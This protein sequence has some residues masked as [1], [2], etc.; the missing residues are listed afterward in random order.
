MHSLFADI[1]S[2]IAEKRGYPCVIQKVNTIGGGCINQCYR[3]FT[4]VGSFFLKINRLPFSGDMF[5]KERVGLLTLAESGVVR[6]PEVIAIGHSEG[7][8]YLLLE[9]IE[10]GAPTPRHWQLAG[11]CLA[12]MHYI[13]SSGF[14]WEYDNYI[15]SLPQSNRKHSCFSDFFI[16][17]RLEPQLKRAL[18]KQL[19]DNKIAACFEKL[20]V[21]LP[22]LLPDEPPALLHGDL[23]SGNIF[24]DITGSPVL[25]DPAV[26][27]GNREAEI[28]FTRLFGSFDN[29]FYEAYLFEY[30][31]QKGFESRTDIYN[32]YPLLVHLNLFGSAY[33][34]DII[35]IMKKYS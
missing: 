31:M 6:T 25:V 15:G 34:A 12:R 3:L 35:T 28:A 17:E 22:N 21:R 19:I 9:Y 33:L 11:K 30:P 16:Y 5:E 1:Q 2:A 8:Y 26:H 13:R 23:W 29:S 10:R 20:Y 14:G 24:F 4:T 32:L 7:N 27:F 18:G